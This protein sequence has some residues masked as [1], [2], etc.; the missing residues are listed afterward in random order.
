MKTRFLYA[1]VFP[2]CLLAQSGK[3]PIVT[4]D[5]LKIRN[6]TDVKVAPDGSFAVYALQSIHTEP[7][8]NAKTEPTYSYRTNLYLIDLN[9]PAA[10]PTQLTSGDRSDGGLALSPDG[11]T[12]AF[13]RAETSGRERHS[14]IWTLPV[15]G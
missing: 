2:V 8:A 12:L 10:K 7:G 6:V 5:L 14:Q 9:D 3:Q 4:T 13:T 15:H 11:K 1:A